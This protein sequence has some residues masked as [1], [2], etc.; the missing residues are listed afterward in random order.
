ML[1]VESRW[2]VC[3]CSMFSLSSLLCLKIFMMKCQGRVAWRKSPMC[4]LG[5][6][7]TKVTSPDWVPCPHREGI[8]WK[9]GWPRQPLLTL[10]LSIWAK[11]KGFPRGPGVQATQQLETQSPSAHSG[12]WE[13]GEGQ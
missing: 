1:M 11:E 7:G 12:Q 3:G 10:R 6:S 5:L 9:P 2:Q 4:W 8:L 13:L